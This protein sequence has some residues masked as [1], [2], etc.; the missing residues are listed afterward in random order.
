MPVLSV[1]RTSILP[2][3]GIAV[4][5]LTITPLLAIC[6]EPL[7]IA[8]VSIMGRNSGVKPTA[9]ATAKVRECKISPLTIKLTPKIT[10]TK[11]V[12]IR[13]IKILKRFIPETNSLSSLDLERLVA[14]LPN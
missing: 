6:I 11:M 2:K 12:I 8:T 3:V 1:Q 7:L 10:I 14:I 13:T 9:I 4:S 5:F